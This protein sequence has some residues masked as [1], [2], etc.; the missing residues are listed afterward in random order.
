MSKL[1]YIKKNLDKTLVLGA[2]AK[3]V[4]N[5]GGN[6]NENEELVLQALKRAVPD[7]Q[8]KNLD[9]I[10]EYLQG[11]NE[12]QLVGLANNV[13]G[14]LHEI[15]FVKIENEDGD[16]ITAALFTDT[17]HPDTD[18]ILTNESSGETITL[19]LKA[20]DSD[21]YVNNWISNH[22][23]GDI[24][25]TEEIAEKMGLESTEI[26]NEGLTADVS[27]FCNKLI[28]LDDNDSLWDYMPELPAISIAIAGYYLF[29]E[30]NK[31]KISFSTFKIKFIKLTGIKVAKFT[32]IAVLM[33][34]PVINVVIGASLLFS[35]LYN[36]GSFLNK[37][38]N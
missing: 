34:I 17:N 9:E 36:T 35:F 33:M 27:E 13:K 4:F 19:Q 2:I 20:T 21:S 37:N 5:N 29:S 32:F 22:E 11:F 28:N 38:I 26:S 14:V 18:V 3:I 6:L 8:E 23:D 31:G 10:Q 12:D 7:L 24:L 25:V 1:K 30:Y 15:Q 16:E